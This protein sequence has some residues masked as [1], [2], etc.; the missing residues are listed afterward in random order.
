MN[1]PTNFKLQVRHLSKSGEL[2]GVYNC[3][4][5]QISVFRSSNESDLQPFRRAFAGVPGPERIRILLDDVDF[6]ISEGLTIGLAE[7]VP[8]GVTVKQVLLDNGFSE[9]SMNGQLTHCGLINDKNTELTALSDCARR[10]V[11]ILV[12]LSSQNKVLICDSPFEPLTG[13]W[14]ERFAELM[15]ENATGS[16]KIIVVTRLDYRP[17]AW[18]DNSVINRLQVNSTVQK[19]IGFATDGDD[20]QAAVR[21]V[22]E[23][24]AEQASIE[25]Q[26]AQQRV[27][28][29]TTIPVQDVAHNTSSSRLT[30]AS[31]PDQS[32]SIKKKMRRTGLILVGGSLS[33]VIVAAFILRAFD[34]NT[35][36]NKLP[37]KQ[38]STNITPTTPASVIKQAPKLVISSGTLAT[39][40][41][42]QKLKYKILDRY[43]VPIKQAII[44]TFNEKIPDSQVRVE[45]VKTGGTSEENPFRTLMDVTRNND[46]SVSNNNTPVDS[47]F[48][49]QPSVGSAEVSDEDRRQRQELIRQK[50]LEAIQ[51]AAERRQQQ[52]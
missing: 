43:P 14:K 25:E 12:A 38:S 28:I 44:D 24:M 46:T 26:Q 7:K 4:A 48:V 3:P 36:S 51:R 33:L 5:G 27:A 29:S 42:T 2:L 52:Q 32:F 20:V 16:D 40:S 37:V 30:S 1:S 15:L 47:T 34:S 39:P 35:N 18:I 6:E 21:K 50:F 11:A 9:D 10:R 45:P 49:A 31:F 17:E 8:V 13:V 22:R 23:M 41:P 19:T